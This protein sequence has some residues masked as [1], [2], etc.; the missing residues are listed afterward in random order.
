MKRLSF[1]ITDLLNHYNLFLK[2][3]ISIIM[4]LI[5]GQLQ[6]QKLTKVYCYV[7]Y[8]PAKTI[9]V[10]PAYTF[11]EKP[12]SIVTISNQSAENPV[13]AGCWGYKDRWYG[14]VNNDNTLITM[15]IASGQKTVIGSLGVSITAL[16]Y[17]FKEMQFYGISYDNNS[18]LSSLYKIN[19]LTGTAELIGKAANGLLINL[20]CDT[21]GNL[22]SLN[23]SNDSLYKLN[24]IT[25]I[26][27]SIGSVGFDANYIQGMAFDMKTNICY[28]AAYNNTNS[29]GELRI[30]DVETGKTELIGAFKNKAEI[31]ALAIPYLSQK[32]KDVAAGVIDCRAVLTTGNFIPIAKVINYGLESEF[33]VSFN[34]YAQGSVQPIYQ[35]NQ[36]VKN[37]TSF[38]TRQIAFEKWDAVIGNYNFELVVSLNEDY[39]NNNDTLRKIVSVQDLTTAYCYVAYDPANLLPNGPAYTFLQQPE[40]VISISDQVSQSMISG[41]AWA[42]GGKWYA[43]SYA[44]K[45]LLKIDTLNGSRTL[46]GNT[47]VGMLDI[48]YDY[49]TSVLYGI[50]YDGSLYSLLYKI[51]KETANSVLIGRIIQGVLVTLACDS[52][53]NL[54]SL[55]LSDNSLYFI[56]KSTAAP[57]LIGDV[58]FDAEYLQGM[59]FDIKTN[60]CYMAA[61]NKTSSQGEMRIADIKTGSSSLL[62]VF[63][64]QAEITGFAIPFYFNAKIFDIASVSIDVP[65]ILPLQEFSPEARIMNKGKNTSCSVT[66]KI[67][68]EGFDTACY[69]STRNIDN[70]EPK[71]GR[72]IVFDKWLPSEGKYKIYVYTNL[73]GDENKSNDTLTKFIEVK[74][75]T[76]AYCYV[77][78]DTTGLLNIGPAYLYLEEP[79]IIK[80]LKDQANQPLIFNSN[81]GS[82]N[83]WFA[84][85]KNK[86]ISVDTLTGN[87]VTMCDLDRKIVS[88]AFDYSSNTL[89]GIANEGNEGFLYKISI[90]TGFTKLVG[91]CQT[92]IISH[93]ACDKTG[94]IF[95]LSKSDN[96]LYSLNKK[97]GIGNKIGALNISV[98]DIKDMEID[99]NSGFGYL[100]VF[101]PGNFEGEIRTLDLTNGNTILLGTIAGRKNV[102]ITGLAIPYNGLVPNIDLGVT[103]HKAPLS[104]C[105][106]SLETVVIAVE[107]TGL[108]T[109]NNIP[110][111]YMIDG[112]NIID[113]LLN[114]TLPAGNFIEF[115]FKKKVDI[116]VSGLHTIKAYTT[117]AGDT[118]KEN[119]TLIYQVNN[120]AVSAIPYKLGFEADESGW[121]IADANE[122]AVK[123]YVSSKN[124]VNDSYSAQFTSNPEQ[125]SDDYLFSPCIQFEKGKTYNLSFSYKCKKNIAPE[126]LIV[127]LYNQTDITGFVSML[128]DLHSISNT[129][130]QVKNALFTVPDKG[131]YYLVFRC[132][133]WKGETL[134]L[135]DINITDVTGVEENIADYSK[136]DNVFP[137]PATEKISILSNDKIKS[138][139]INNIT[140]QEIKHFTFSNT[141]KNTELDISELSE[142]IYILTIQTQNAI[143]IK[144]QI[145][146]R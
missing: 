19:R 7:A 43:S 101:Y 131:V 28:M 45:S 33:N 143:I 61:Y 14:T 13:Y 59:E 46:I 115:G 16:A 121:F 4:I 6:A 3:L 135:D 11:L 108:E 85:A 66:F 60:I 136:Y 125:N 51:D 24:K 145:I 84:L 90:A 48:A 77:N 47:I 102:E 113:T 114:N 138:V 41:G 39:D 100:S 116:S 132:Y 63:A 67:I 64:N 55:N 70:L 86:L 91:A 37:L 15:D 25:G 27:S 71:D 105:G 1:I 62:G 130:Y 103:V 93:I 5:I 129:D 29:Q 120:I 98:N 36:T 81:W 52:L 56:N 139:K 22:F 8:D 95:I 35:S 10:G 72:Q 106:L 53:G 128:T 92:G 12:D 126:A 133:S 122:D 57:T 49:T 146:R 117:L 134:F 96:Y 34:I 32:V 40:Q 65:A 123:W 104:G 38:D 99:R 73:I 74:R 26:A 119:D 31:T 69:M 107:N 82:N 54:Y 109:V 20:A 87:R 75:L 83:K 9:P 17:D 124:G 79:S 127:M 140:G 97:I 23:I 111:K 112:A 88:I 137:N 144:K 89:Y 50:S 80:S 18:S 2:I 30:I 76:K 58:G 78:S 44:E 21:L 141:E 118:N 42:P 110:V 94:N 142:G 68:P